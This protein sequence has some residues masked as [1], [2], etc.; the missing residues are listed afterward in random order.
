MKFLIFFIFLSINDLKTKLLKE[1]FN[2]SLYLKYKELSFRENKLEELKN[3]S[4]ELLKNYKKEILLLI[5]LGEIE[6]LNKNLAQGLSYLETALKISS[7]SNPAVLKLL[8]KYKIENNLE[9]YPFI[10]FLIFIKKNNFI[11]AKEAWHFLEEGELK[12]YYQLLLFGNLESYDSLLIAIF[13]FLV[14]YEKSPLKEAVQEL[15]LL[16]SSG[17]KIK[18]YF[19]SLLLLIIGEKEKAK[20][21]LKKINEDY[22]L[23]KLAEIYEKEGKI[24]LAISTLKNV[25]QSKD[26]YFKTK[27]Q[28]QLA[29]LLL[30]KNE[31]EAISLLSDIVF[32]QPLTPYTYYSRE[33]LNKLKLKGIR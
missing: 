18:E 27:A 10:N 24:S 23:I 13:N 30:D 12:D 29:L 9:K 26:N 16:L 22:A 25:C 33:L 21:N 3:L 4:L 31:K 7:E 1:G 11:K 19:Y 17:K 5:T 32:N 14:N 8:E 6:L 2:D 28:Y 20:E 15:G